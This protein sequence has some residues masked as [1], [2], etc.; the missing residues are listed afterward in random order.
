MHRFHLTRN[1]RSLV[2]LM[3][4]AAVPAAGWTVWWANRTG[5]P[6]SWRTAIERELDKQGLHVEIGALSYLPLR[7]VAASKV[8]VF[9][10][11]T[12]LHEISSFERVMMAFDKTK[13]ARGDVH[14]NHL[15]LRDAALSL[16]ID[17][18]DLSAGI[19]EIKG[20]NGT[21]LMPGKR[22]FEIRDA[23]GRISG[24]DVSLNARLTG[25]RHEGGTGEGKSEDGKRREI[26]ARIIQELERWRFEAEQPPAIR[27]FL[28]ADANQK[29]ALTASMTVE[30]RQLE[31][32]GHQLD[33]LS[34]EVDLSGD[35]LT[36]TRL[37]AADTR[38]TLDARGDYDMS[39]REG[40]FDLDCSL[41]IA[42]LLAA[43]FDLSLPGRIVIG[44][45]QSLVAEGTF[46]MDADHKPRI[47]MTGHLCTEAL[48]LRGVP[49]DTAECAFSWRDGELFLRDVRLTR[50]DGVA[51]GKA[52]FQPPMLRMA[53]HS[54][55][56]AP[57]YKP[58]FTGQPLE[59][60]IDDFSLGE[61]A[62]FDIRLD[63][64]FD[65]TDHHSWAYTGGGT[66]KNVGYR[67]V[68]VDEAA[69]GFSLSH[70]E[71]DFFGGTVVF[72]YK[73]Y[74]LRTTFNG[75]LGGT[76]KV[77][78]IRY[79]SERKEVD[80]EGVEGAIWAAPLV[81]LFSP[82]V[83]D[84][85]EV[86]RFHRPP[87][88]KGSGVVDVTPRGR[89][90]LDISFQSRDSADYHFL[91]ENLTLSRPSGKVA[92][93]GPKVT[94]ADLKLD[95]FDG[96]VTAG[97]DFNG[98]G[99]IDGEITW[100]G[101]SIPALASTYG[102]QIK[103]GG[104]VTGRLE[105]SMLEGRMET[106]KGE[107]LLALEKTELFSVPVF[108]PL[109]LVISGVLN[110]RRAGFERAKNAFCTFR[111]KDG[112]LRTTDF[113]TATNSLTFAGDGELDLSQR[114]MDMTM[115]MNARGLL[116]LITLPLR[117]FYG[118][119]QFRGTGPIKSP[120]W[121]N[122]MFTTPPPD[123]KEFLKEPPKALVVPGAE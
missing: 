58:F 69:C 25:Y 91:G 31:R 83:A 54:T 92:I 22:R 117:P 30:A 75:P 89:T 67:G 57:V 59:Q 16:P 63:G 47:H 72:N 86:Y 76:A 24:I 28:E 50:P 111:I 109:S 81:R 7:G 74:P 3:I 78:R 26:L 34:A 19:L 94:V 110:N 115:R 13:L 11:S 112:V 42:P 23:R 121:E 88:L 55:L 113:H 37:K 56:P 29:S 73:D 102:F 82:E 80:V 99:G 93:R 97:L 17:P 46:H 114:T 40:R 27:I 122:V 79:V 6:E 118:M 90:S 39:D 8:R 41:E 116:G 51:S 10:D 105:F 84:T 12:R 119:F 5:L 108:G 15:E 9:S 53:L 36:I 2:F 52:M 87:L 14:L 43:W 49:F 104:T 103:A 71:L 4:A 18:D 44:G 21:I 101:L 45:A 95:A 123:Q 38:G 96:P 1:L 48:M 20:A 85:L 100:T 70:H 35:L 61:G 120:E 68:P 107:G 32:N 65:I 98:A 77:G 106:M 33:S 62:S 64:G 66:V 60:V